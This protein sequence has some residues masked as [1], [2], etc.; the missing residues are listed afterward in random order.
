MMIFGNIWWYLMMLDDIWLYKKIIYDDIW[1]CMMIYDDMFWFMMIYD[2][3]RW[4]DDIWWYM[5]IYDDIWWYMMIS[6]T[7]LDIE[8]F[9]QK[10]M[11]FHDV[12]DIQKTG[13]RIRSSRYM[14]KMM[15]AGMQNL[16]VFLWFDVAVRHRP[17]WTWIEIQ[18]EKACE[19]TLN[20]SFQSS[21]H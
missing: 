10:T 4:Y 3:T 9:K 8:S 17:W 6:C 12:P 5:M 18:E 19:W 13:S 11:L 21:M 2:D 16:I 7:F 14:M 1:W 20:G 15:Y